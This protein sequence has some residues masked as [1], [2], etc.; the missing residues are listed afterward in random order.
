M[1]ACVRFNKFCKAIIVSFHI[2]HTSVCI[3]KMAQLSFGRNGR[4]EGSEER[5]VIVMPRDVLHNGACYSLWSKSTNI[6]VHI[7]RTRSF[8]LVNVGTYVISKGRAFHNSQNIYFHYFNLR[9]Q[10]NGNAI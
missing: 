5:E 4:S 10:G 9:V 2:F 6:H 8:Q 3:A 1:F 7:N